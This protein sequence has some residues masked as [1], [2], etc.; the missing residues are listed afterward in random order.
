[1]RNFAAGVNRFRLFYFLYFTA[2]GAYTAFMN[3]H[4]KRLGLSGAEIGRLSAL[5]PI[6]T[7][8]VPPVV[9]AWVDLR[10]Q[11]RRAV[12]ASLLASLVVFSLYLTATSFWPLFVISLLFALVNTPLVPLADSATLDHLAQHGSH[13]SRV[14]VFGSIGFAAGAILAGQVQQRLGGTSAAGAF[15]FLYLLAAGM[16]L[17]VSLTFPAEGSHPA[18]PAGEKPLTPGERFLLPWKAILQQKALLSFLFALFLARASSVVY[19]NFFSIYLNEL[20]VTES[21]IGVTWAVAIAGEVVLM[22]LA[23]FLIRR[24]GSRNLLLLSI[25][26]SAVRWGLYA[27]VHSHTAVAVAQLLHG[28]TF[29]TLWVAAVTYVDEQTPSR[30]RASSQA[31]LAAVSNGLAPALGVL[32]AGYLYA[33]TDQVAPLFF[34]ASLVAL[35][36]AIYFLVYLLL[37]KRSAPP[38]AGI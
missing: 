2:F 33:Q 15:L 21:G 32:A 3:L 8:V 22:T 17:L 12:A 16:A 14:R 36:A 34:Y 35:A 31:L 6:A 26:A 29:A 18:L 11:K 5:A 28:F 27:Q 1:M 7:L 10:W 24:F 19:Y 25:I 20:G 9:A 38:P 30:W 4:F 13:Y 37:E 23:P